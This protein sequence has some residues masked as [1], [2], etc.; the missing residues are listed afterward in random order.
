MKLRL[1]SVFAVAALLGSASVYADDTHHDS[2]NGQDGHIH[3]D[4][5]DICFEFVVTRDHKLVPHNVIVPAGKAFKIVI[6]N[7][8]DRQVEFESAALVR[9]KNI[10]AHGHAFLHMGPLDP[11]TYN[12]FDEVNRGYLNSN[13]IAQTGV[14]TC[15]AAPQP[16]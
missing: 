3:H 4:D 9:E 6:K 14:T 5:H 11:G 1:V 16:K 2:Q 15:S 10:P 7:F 13:L 8:G 12:L